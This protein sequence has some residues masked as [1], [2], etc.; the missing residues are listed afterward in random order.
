M[1]SNEFVMKAARVMLSA[2]ALIAL[3]WQ[4]AAAAPAVA[5]TNVNLRQGPGTASPAITT[6][7]AGAPIDVTSCEGQWCQV[8][9]QGQSGFVIATSVG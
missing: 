9:F 7:P 3:S 8:T 5:T 4:Y 6:I 1:E 2:T